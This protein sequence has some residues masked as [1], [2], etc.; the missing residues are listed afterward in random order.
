MKNITLN[1]TTMIIALVA[2]PSYVAY[3][4]FTGEPDASVIAGA[5]LTIIALLFIV[6]ARI[7]LG[8]SF[9]VTPQA[10]QLVTRG[11]YSKIRHPIYVFAQFLILGMILCI[12]MYILFI[13]WAVLIFI[14]VSRAKSEEKILEEKFGD[15]YRE[16]KRNTWF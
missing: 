8:H 12:K 11:L 7:Q 3:I 13:V 10:H 4:L 16:Y 1:Y 14:Q 2:I 5:A 9:S 15:A 6:I